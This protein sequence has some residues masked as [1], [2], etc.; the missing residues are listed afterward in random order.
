MDILRLHPVVIF[1]ELSNAVKGIINTLK[2][3]TVSGKIVNLFILG[4]I[5]QIAHQNPV[6]EPSILDEQ[7]KKRA[8][9]SEMTKKF[10]EVEGYTVSSTQ[11][12]DRL[13]NGHG[14]SF[15]RTRNTG[16]NPDYMEGDLSPEF[17]SSTYAVHDSKSYTQ[18]DISKDASLM[19]NKSRMEVQSNKSS[20][21]ANGKPSI[22][23]RNINEKAGQD[24]QTKQVEHK[25]VVNKDKDSQF[26][27]GYNPWW[28]KLSYVLV[29]NSSPILCSF[30]FP[31]FL[32]KQGH[33]ASL[34]FHH[35]MQISYLLAPD[36]ISF[37]TMHM[38]SVSGL[39]PVLSFIIKSRMFRI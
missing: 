16:S 24:S 28:L 5:Q 6:K 2:S 23:N 33:F 1:D 22:I 14:M 38:V 9:R 4:G 32:T 34:L 39:A 29:C 36:F 18:A 13:E 26:D 19:E 31:S 25:S 20:T 8:R 17:S 3:I 12:T 27:K 11:E 35:I 7:G 15:S 37:G 30:I 10:A 21:K